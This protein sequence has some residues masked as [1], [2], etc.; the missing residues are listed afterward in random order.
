[1]I[2]EALR[3]DL[4]LGFQAA[5]GPGMNDAVAIALEGIAVRMVGLGIA[6]PPALADVKTEAPQHGASPLLLAQLRVELNRFLADVLV[7]GRA[8]RLDQAAGLGR[9][10]FSQ[11][12]RE[13]EGRLLLGNEFSGVRDQVAQDRLAF[14][15]PVL[16]KI[17]LRERELGLG[18]EL[19]VA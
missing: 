15:A 14:L 8:Q 11:G 9:V 10:A 16:Q 6:S 5:K 7:R 3:E 4:R 12:V 2:G 13:R 17:E 19:L 1:M 18:G